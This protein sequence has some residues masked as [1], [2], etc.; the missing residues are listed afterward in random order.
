MPPTGQTSIERLFPGGRRHCRRRSRGR[1]RAWRVVSASRT[2]QL[3][4]SPSR[5]HAFST[6]QLPH[7]RT[8]LLRY[9]Y[10]VR[11]YVAFHF[12]CSYRMYLYYYTCTTFVA[13][14]SRG[15]A[16]LRIPVALFN[17]FVARQRPLLSNSMTTYSLSVRAAFTSRC[18]CQLV[19]RSAV[20]LNRMSLFS[21]ATSHY[22]LPRRASRA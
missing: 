13:F 5:R 6:S 8:P 7:S 3:V 22:R 9:S 10:F 20:A 4:I 18:D 1:V 19:R 21:V 12:S 15:R 11:R 17:A 2:R 16:D 14:T